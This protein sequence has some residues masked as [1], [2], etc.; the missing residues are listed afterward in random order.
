MASYA[1]SQ[2]VRDSIVFITPG[3][4]VFN[5]N[6]EPIEVGWAEKT[7]RPNTIDDD[8]SFRLPRR[9]LTSARR[10]LNTVAL[11][12]WTYIDHGSNW[13]QRTRNGLAVGEAFS[14]RRTQVSCRVTLVDV[15]S[16]H[17]IGRREF[18]GSEPRGQDTGSD[19]TGDIVNY[20]KEAV[21]RA[22][23]DSHRP[24]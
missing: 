2:A 18:R 11:L 9:I 21:E 16:K 10:D 14:V 3:L 19:P 1:D 13:Y 17:V 23:E 15:A 5:I 20:L 22:A 4:A 7:K 8:V 24:A 6:R 12:D